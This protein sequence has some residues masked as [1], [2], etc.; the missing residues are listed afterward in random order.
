LISESHISKVPVPGLPPGIKAIPDG[1]GLGLDHAVVSM[2]CTTWALLVEAAKGSTERAAGAAATWSPLRSITA[3]WI[4]VSSG[5]GHNNRDLLDFDFDMGDLVQWMRS[6]ANSAAKNSRRAPV[7]CLP[8]ALLP[9][10][11][12]GPACQPVY[13]TEMAEF[14]CQGLK[15]A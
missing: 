10:A 9:C 1:S 3:D 2:I 15:K 4:D 14:S 7:R 13:S 6:R 5:S 12:C 11:Y 8:P